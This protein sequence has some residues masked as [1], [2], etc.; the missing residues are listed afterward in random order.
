[1]RRDSADADSHGGRD[2][3]RRGLR[4]RRPGQRPAVTAVRL[5]GSEVGMSAPPAPG[6]LAGLKVLDCTHVIAGASCSLMLA[7]LGADVIKIE[8]PTGEMTRG[9]ARARFRAFDFVNRN[10]RA[11]A[12]DLT[13]PEGADVI[14]RLAKS[15]DVFVE[16]YRPGVLD[17]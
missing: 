10:K 6:A 13:R 2:E 7:D 15:A 17:K 5:G 8:P 11:I 1:A 9:T 16:N 12:V 4:P 14:R 3:P